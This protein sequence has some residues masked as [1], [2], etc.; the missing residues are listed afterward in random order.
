MKI[1]FIDDEYE[2]ALPVA[3]YLRFE[4]HEVT[5]ISVAS[6]AFAYFQAHKNCID[7]IILDVMMPVF[8][9]DKILFDS[10]NNVAVAYS[11]GFS[12]YEKFEV[13]MP[14][15][16]CIPI[17]FFSARRD[18]LEERPDFERLERLNKIVILTKPILIDELLKI[19]SDIYDKNSDS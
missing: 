17:I 3:E 14:H 7:I 13:E 18:I 1:L 10:H 5:L 2:Q 9:P 19:L 4:D 15:K 16:K 8:E 6:D 12:L 11:T